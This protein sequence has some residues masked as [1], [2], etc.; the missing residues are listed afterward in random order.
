MD[1]LKNTY[2][3]TKKFI[4]IKM[5]NVQQKFQKTHNT[6]LKTCTTKQSK[7]AQNILKKY[8]NMLS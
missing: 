5:L 2:V 8:K 7:N 1:T 6:L 4:K 3:I